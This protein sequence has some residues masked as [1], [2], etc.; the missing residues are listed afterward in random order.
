MDK[1]NQRRNH[2]RRDKSIL[3]TKNGVEGIDN[4]KGTIDVGKCQCRNSRLVLDFEEFF[5]VGTEKAGQ[6]GG[7]LDAPLDFT[8]ASSRSLAIYH[9]NQ[10]VDNFL[11]MANIPFVGQEFFKALGHRCVLGILDLGRVF[12][13]LPSTFKTGE[14]LQK[15]V[16][17]WNNLRAAIL[18]GRTWLA[19]LR[20]SGLWFVVIALVQISTIFHTSS[21]SGKFVRPDGTQTDRDI[22]CLV[23]ISQSLGQCGGL[24]IFVSFWYT[25]KTRWPWPLFRNWEAI[26][27]FKFFFEALEELGDSMKYNEGHQNYRQVHT[28]FYSR[29]SVYPTLKKRL[30]NRHFHSHQSNQKKV[31]NVVSLTIFCI[32]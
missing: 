18:H 11:K 19:I 31:R 32:L 10:L 28:P 23:L 4:P 30:A 25:E 14:N 16:P 21:F 9:G 6:D 24:Q 13:Q 22:F 1:R 15:T 20:K 17:A 3:L 26:T 2:D 27:D 7:C 5:I 29:F 12:V 8:C